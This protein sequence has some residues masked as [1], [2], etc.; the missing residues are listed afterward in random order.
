MCVC[1]PAIECILRSY[2]PRGEPDETI[3]SDSRL[4]SDP[5]NEKP[6]RENPARFFLFRSRLPSRPPSRPPSRSEGSEGK[7]GKHGKRGKPGWGLETVRL[8]ARSFIRTETVFSDRA[9]GSD[10]RLA[11]DGADQPGKKGCVNRFQE[12]PIKNSEEPRGKI[13][14]GQEQTGFSAF[15]RRS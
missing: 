15:Q 4:P 2:R 10:F 7:R 3:Q 6:R 14:G 13:I 5:T 11:A 12:A 1:N 9:F 8:A